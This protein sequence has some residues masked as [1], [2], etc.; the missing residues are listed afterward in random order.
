VLI[1]I[2]SKSVLLLNT[3]WQ[4]VIRFTQKLPIQKI[5]DT[6]QNIQKLFTKLLSCY[7]IIQRMKT[8]NLNFTC[9][10]VRVFVQHSSTIAL[11]WA[12]HC[13]LITTA[14]PTGPAVLITLFHSRN[15]AWLFTV[16]SITHSLLCKK[17]ILYPSQ[18]LHGHWSAWGAWYAITKAS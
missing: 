18:L 7:E 5:L 16:H 3:A 13:R 8:E 11:Q 1:L 17:H 9:V 12:I 10:K 4:T 6:I 15:A 14:I 2:W